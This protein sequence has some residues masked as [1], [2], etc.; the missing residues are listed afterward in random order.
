MTLL[1]PG[2]LLLTSW[3]VG[4]LTIRFIKEKK[5]VLVLRRVGNER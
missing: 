2:F 1:L 4:V 3:L 5:V